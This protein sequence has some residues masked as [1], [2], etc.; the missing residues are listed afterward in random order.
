MT[1]PGY[2]QHVAIFPFTVHMYTE[3]QLHLFQTVASIPGAAMYFDATG[4]IF[5]AIS[6]QKRV[7]YY[8]LVVQGAQGEPPI[9]VAEMITTDHTAVNIQIF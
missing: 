5:S 2:V 3:G 9:P 7:F 1:V 4:S 8:S 6:K